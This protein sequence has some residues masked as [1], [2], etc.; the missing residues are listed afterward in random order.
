MNGLIFRA[1][2]VPQRV[3]LLRYALFRGHCKYMEKILTSCHSYLSPQ[4]TQNPSSISAKQSVQKYNPVLSSKRGLR[5]SSSFS[6]SASTSISSSSPPEW[7]SSSW[8]LSTSTGSWL[9]LLFM[10]RRS[11]AWSLLIS[12]SLCFDFWRWDTYLI[13]KSCCRNLVTFAHQFLNPK[14]GF[15]LWKRHIGLC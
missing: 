1:L 9:A 3:F 10:N 8:S 5:G 2:C 14:L 4:S 15:K 13:S 11:A 12:A 6:V 7:I